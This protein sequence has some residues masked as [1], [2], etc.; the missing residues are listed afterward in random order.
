MEKRTGIQICQICGFDSWLDLPDPVEGRAVTTAGRIINESLGKAQCSRCGFAQRTRAQFLGLTDYYEEDYAKY[1]D[2]P[3]TGQFH[4]ARYRLLAQWMVAVLDSLSPSTI[5]DVGCGQGWGMEAMKAFYPQAT[6][7]GVEPSRDNSEVARQKGFRVH[8][9]R[10]AD[11]GIPPLRYDL[12]YSNNVIQ[13]VTD[14]REFLISLKEL[15]GENGVIVITCPDGSIPNIE[16]LWADQNF[17]FLPAHLASLCEEVGFPAPKWFS[18]PFSASVPPAQL[19][20][21][22]NRREREAFPGMDVPAANLKEV[23]RARCQYL[24]SFAEID[25]YFCARVK[26]SDRVF[27]FGASYWSSILAAYCPRYWQKVSACLVDNTGNGDL[28]FL[29]KPVLETGSIESRQ[30]DALILGTSPVTHDAL[31]QKLLRSWS[32]IV[33]W[34]HFAVQS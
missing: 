14:A 5:L 16:I 32:H 12:I 11:A 3:G 33:S 15:A 17:S 6:I 1:Y 30:T 18:S 26:D 20:L 27:N 13:H 24:R 9:G 10:V 7:Q 25:N 2:R 31:R 28:E 23:Y 29:D 34:D 22:D 4:A 19:L 21:F 8:E